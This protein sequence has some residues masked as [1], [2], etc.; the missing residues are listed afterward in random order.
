MTNPVRIKKL[1]KATPPGRFRLSKTRWKKFTKLTETLAQRGVGVL[2]F[3]PPMH[4]SLRGK[5]SAADADGTPLSNYQALVAKMLRYDNEQPNVVFVD[6]HRGGHHSFG[7]QLFADFD[8]LNDAG[9]K[10]LTKQLVAPLELLK[11]DMEQSQKAKKT[12]KRNKKRVK[13][14][15]SARKSKRIAARSKRKGKAKIS[16]KKARRSNSA[17]GQGTSSL[18]LKSMLGKDDYAIRS[19]PP[20]NRPVIWAQYSDDKVGIDLKSVRM[21]VDGV[22]DGG[23]QDHSQPNPVSTAKEL[24]SADDSYVSS[25]GQESQRGPDRA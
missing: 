24:N 6:L 22:S 20:D 25:C 3:I 18:K 8:H 10:A 7:G 13:R 19:F 12:D 21:Y 2:I 17:V 9:A 1:L 15:G 5:D 16:K 4:P 14:K 11:R 23:C